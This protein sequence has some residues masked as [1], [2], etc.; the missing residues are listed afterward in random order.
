M[1]RIFCV[2]LCLCMFAA[3][4]AGCASTSE[5]SSV[6]ESS[7]EPSVAESLIESVAESSEESTTE[8]ASEEGGSSEESAVAE[9]YDWDFNKGWDVFAGLSGDAGVVN[10]GPVTPVA[11]R[12]MVYHEFEKKPK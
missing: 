3:L 2:F 8:T 4:L 10:A 6:V 1:K 9:L 7:S 12:I 5:E 11:Q